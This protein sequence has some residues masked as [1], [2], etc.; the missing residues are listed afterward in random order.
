ARHPAAVEHCCRRG[1]S[2]NPSFVTCEQYA[3]QSTHRKHVRCR[4]AM[5][6]CCQHN[7][8]LISDFDYARAGMGTDFDEV[9]SLVRSYFPESWLWEVQPLQGKRLTVNRTLPDSLTTWEITA[10]G[11]FQN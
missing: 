1:L 10:V 7:L 8:E 2:Y 4:K 5:I 6:D 3:R 11:M 9:P